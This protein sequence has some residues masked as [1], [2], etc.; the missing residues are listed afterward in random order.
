MAY[1]IKSLVKQGVYRDLEEIATSPIIDW[2]KLKGTTILITGA[3]GFI[4]YHLTM[5]LL[6]RNDLFG[7]EISVIA[8]VRNKEKA[9]AKYGDV[10]KRFDLSLNVS[11]VTRFINATGMD[12]IIHAASQASNIQFENDPVGTIN[13]N[14]SGTSNVL[15]LA[16][17][18]GA[19]TLIV[20]SLKVYGALKTG[21]DRI[22]ESDIGVIDHTS[23]KSCYA[24]GKRA[25]ETLAASYAKQYGMKI[26]I[27]RP[28]YIYGA[29]SLDDDR[30][31]AQFIA[32]IVRKQDILLKSSGAPLRSFCYVTDTCTA[33][34]KIMLDGENAAP[35]NIANKASDVTIR[36]FARAACEVF[37]ERDMHLSFANKEDEAE[38]VRDTSP[39]APTPEILDSE[40][41][42]SLGWAPKVDLHEGIRRAVGILEENDV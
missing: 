28:S 6:L 5:A 7:D 42:M 30:V 21:N 34:F 3:G 20:S 38:P 11:D 35:Y 24:V 37:P 4:G 15:E 12:Y 33:L 26:K 14:L 32:N 41:L 40:R 31:W 1:E 19:V 16:R 39:N 18:N 2:E 25:S 29:S 9:Y 17:E 36:G 27:A 22:F 8:N 10:L 13:A 23:Y